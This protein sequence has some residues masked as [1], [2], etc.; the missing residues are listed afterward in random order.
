[1]AVERKPVKG[2]LEV[3]TDRLSHERPHLAIWVKF[4]RPE[5]MRKSSMVSMMNI[6]KDLLKFV[7]LERAAAI[8]SLSWIRGLIF[9]QVTSCVV[10]TKLL[11]IKHLSRFFKHYSRDFITLFSAFVQGR[12]ADVSGTPERAIVVVMN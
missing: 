7:M 1:M 3:L 5:D 8:I 10:T 12:S 9:I 6:R 2:L 4:I 11:K